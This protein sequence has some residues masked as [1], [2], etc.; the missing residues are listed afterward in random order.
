MGE[1]GGYG[2]GGYGCI[3]GYAAVMG[4]GVVEVRLVW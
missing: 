1:R 4:I 3:G 2:C